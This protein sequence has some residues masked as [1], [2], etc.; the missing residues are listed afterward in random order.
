MFF[1][2]NIKKT[3][4]QEEELL[5]KSAKY[6]KGTFLEPFVRNRITQKELN[7]AGFANIDEYYKSQFPDY[8]DNKTWKP[9]CKI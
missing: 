6:W 9:T 1:V 3:M 2:L 4:S 5:E 7:D 8:G